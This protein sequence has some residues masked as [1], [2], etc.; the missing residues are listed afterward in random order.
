[1]TPPSPHLDHPEQP[2]AE[3]GLDDPVG[4]PHLTDP[5]RHPA[6]AGAVTRTKRAWILLALTTFLPGS[7][8]LIAG[9]R[10]LG[11]R[12]LTVTFSVWGALILAGLL[13]LLH[14]TWLFALVTGRFTSL[15]LIVALILLA[16]GWAVLFL[17]AL[18]LIRPG[19]LA[20]GMR[21]AVLIGCVVLM[22]LTSGSLGY[23]AYLVGVGRSALNSIFSGGQ[24]FEPVEGRY[25]FLLMGGDAGEDRV[26]RRPDSMTV[27]SVDAKTG[28]AVTIS[29]P[30][31]MQGA[32]FSEDSP[33]WQVFPNGFSCGD[34]C[35][36]NALYPTVAQEHPDLYPDSPDPGAEAM[37][38]AA[39]GITGLDVQAYIVVDMDGFSNLI[40]ALGGI[41]VDVGGRVPIGGGTNEITG[42][43]NPIDG[44]IE[45]GVQ[46]LDGFHALWYARSR[47][48][49]SDYDREA[50]Q[51]CVQ[52]AMLA[53][54][55]PANVLTK[56]QSIT[57]A[58]EQIIETD[59]P[60]AQLSSFVDV[61]LKAKDHELIQYGAAPPYYDD[62]FPTYPDYD[63]LRTDIS[64]VIEGSES[65]QTPTPIAALPAVALVGLGQQMALGETPEE[66]GTTDVELAAELTENGTC[67]VP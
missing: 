57:E 9:N 51:R 14:R 5:L 44:Y 50:R 65:G 1:M 36:L 38:D 41:T 40:D 32:Q 25:N 28:Q 42:E 23:S 8:Q 45:P 30:R 2:A 22:V 20:Q 46:H 10:T 37:K 52:S 4:R 59:I 15:V 58:G 56:F 3:R 67:S 64:G 66:A 47:E 12:A 21:P 11:R 35:I 6:Q 54:L 29:L 19:L 53:Q 61:G 26:G 13:F 49:A 18:R 43:K 24:A 55:D 48:G 60:E 27:F 39:S 63:Q 31:N 34:E 7:A 17:D 16:I 62:L 33:L